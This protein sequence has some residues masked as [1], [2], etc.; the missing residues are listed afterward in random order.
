MAR[1]PH[2]A[3]AEV[4]A[5]ALRAAGLTAQVLSQ[6]DHANVVGF[7]GLAVVRILVPAREY[8]AAAAALEGRLGGSGRGALG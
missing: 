3:E 6:K 7:G 2:E 4:L 1:A 8:R 5:G